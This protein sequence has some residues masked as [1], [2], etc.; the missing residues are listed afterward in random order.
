MRRAFAAL[1][2]IAGLHTGMAGA[3]DRLSGSLTSVGSDTASALVTRWADTFH[4]RHPKAR[5]QI[6]T[7]GSASAPNALIEGAADLGSMSRPMSTAEE[8][9]FH[10][11]Y[12][13]APTRLVVAHDAIAVFV[14]PDN[15]LQR[16]TLAEL[17]AIYSDTR[18]CGAPRAIR[19]WRDLE[20]DAD[21]TL[22]A[23]EPLATGRNNSSGTWEMFRESALCG[24][25]FRA[26]V[27][28]WPGNGAVVATVATNREAI[29]YA[30]LGYVN[31]LVKPLAIGP[32][33]AGVVPDPASVTQGRYP[34]SRVLYIYVNRPPGRALAELPQAFLAYV[35]SDE[36]QALV[37][38]EGFLPLEPDER[39]AQ[40]ALLE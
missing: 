15:P 35:L 33:D 3:D 11:R 32:A 7:P 30:G 29:G 36:G 6:Q 21:A 9:R 34:L 5:F 20:P 39:V 27:I 18:R 17:D 1:L 38:Q 22:G 40:R 2:V 37:R 25:D 16:I 10:A 13:Y 26:E 8:T 12:G 24:G 23:A 14:H 4:A 28:A 19:R 31:G